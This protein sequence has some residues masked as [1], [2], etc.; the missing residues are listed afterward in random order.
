MDRDRRRATSTPTSA[1]PAL[2]SSPARTRSPSA[3]SPTWKKRGSFDHTSVRHATIDSDATIIEAH[4]KSAGCSASRRRTAT[5]SPSWRS[6]GCSRCSTAGRRPPASPSATAI[7]RGCTRTP[8]SSPTSSPARRWRRSPGTTRSATPGTAPPDERPAQPPTVPRRD[9][10]RPA[11]AR[12]QR[13]RRQRDGAARRAARAG[14]RAHRDERHRGVDADARG[15]RGSHVGGAGRAHVAGVEGR[16]LARDAGRRPGHRGARPVG[17]RP[18]SVGRLPLGGHAVASETCALSTL[19]CVDID[20]VRPGE[21]VT[22]QGA[23]IHRH[24]AL[25]PAATSARCTFEFVYFS[26]PDSVWDDRNV[27]HVRQRLGVELATESGVRRR[28]RDPC[29]RLLDPRRDRIR[30]RERPAVQR[31]A[32]QEPL[33]RPHVH[34]AD[35]GHPRPRRGAEVQ[36]AAPRTWPASGSS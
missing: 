20:E 29:A 28:R 26:R 24:Q 9:D 8:G 1:S 16:V 30:R 27:H 35:P 13:Q 21:M 22:L 12:P 25:A 5:A 10:A 18:L 14:F 19:G 36:R 6:S 23:E 15:R 4:E 31:R 33:H 34:R 2:R 32:D 17:F 3:S 7:G 11:G